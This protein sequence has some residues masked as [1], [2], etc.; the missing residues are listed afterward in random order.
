MGTL[1]FNKAIFFCSWILITRELAFLPSRCY[2]QS[3]WERTIEWKYEEAIKPS[4]QLETIRKSEY[5][6]LTAPGAR[7]FTLV[8]NLKTFISLH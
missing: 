5:E 6:F 2:G 3:R 8:I 7:I 4:K 1:S